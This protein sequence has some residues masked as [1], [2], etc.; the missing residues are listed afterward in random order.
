LP[1]LI[2]KKRG[3]PTREQ[4]VGLG[5]MSRVVEAVEKLFKGEIDSVAV[6]KSGKGP[7]EH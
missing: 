2:I 6:A 7:E 1:R 3:V 4:E 5:E